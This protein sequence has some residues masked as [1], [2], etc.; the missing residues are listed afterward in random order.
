MLLERMLTPVAS[1]KA[2]SMSRVDSPRAYISPTSRSIV[3]VRPQRNAK[4]FDWKRSALSR[5]WGASSAIRPSAV[6]RCA[7]S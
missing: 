3:S 7:G 6:S 4:S 2:C 5:T 1:V